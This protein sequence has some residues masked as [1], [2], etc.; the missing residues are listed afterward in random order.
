MIT[1]RLSL[2]TTFFLL[3]ILLLLS[4]HKGAFGSMNPSNPDLPKTVDAWTRPD[5]P[6]TIT[7]DTIFKY[8]NGA[9]E[10]YIGYRFDHLEVF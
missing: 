6:R 8:M 7:A 5:S 1:N 2:K 3:V 4:T 10:L 9:G